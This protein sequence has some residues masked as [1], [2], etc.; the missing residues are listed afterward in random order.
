MM[1]LMR[2]KP[3]RMTVTLEERIADKKVKAEA[4]FIIQEALIK[5]RRDLDKALDAE[6]YATALVAAAN[7]KTH[8]QFAAV[9]ATNAHQFKAACSGGPDTPTNIIEAATR[10]AWL[11]AATD[12]QTAFAFNQGE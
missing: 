2:S 1:P 9:A 6:I 4:R 8:A 7:G 11:R 12:L 3:R 5:A 10:D